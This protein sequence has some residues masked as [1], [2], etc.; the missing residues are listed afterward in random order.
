MSDPKQTNEDQ[1]GGGSELQSTELLATPS[2]DID[3]YPTEETLGTIER[4]EI[5]TLADAQKLMDFVG[6]ATKAYGRYDVEETPK[7]QR[8]T[9]ATGG[10]SGNESVMQA[11]GNN[12]MVTAMY[13]ES[14]HRGGKHVYFLR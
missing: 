7:G 12:H 9:F 1:R 8:V 2:F 10:W 3:G 13:W 14:S 4:W 11:L 6:E 5:R